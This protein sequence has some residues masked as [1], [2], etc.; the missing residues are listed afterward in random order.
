M[1]GRSAQVFK[2]SSVFLGGALVGMVL[3]GSAFAVQGNMWSALKSLE[4]AKSS[5]ISATA[6][7]EGHR[8]KAINLV[9]QAI[10]ETKLGLAAGR[11]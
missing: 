9:N 10:N 11:N 2:Q 4:S 3:T 1:K 8:L 6:N 7:K 5:L